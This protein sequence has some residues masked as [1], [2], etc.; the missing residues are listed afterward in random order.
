MLEPRFS[1]MRNELFA[2]LRDEIRQ[3]VAAM[4]EARDAGQVHA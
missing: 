3:T 4:R 2:L 1:E